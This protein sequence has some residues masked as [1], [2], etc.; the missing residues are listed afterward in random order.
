MPR[1]LLGKSYSKSQELL[2][3]IDHNC[4]CWSSEIL[5]VVFSLIDKMKEESPNLFRT[6]L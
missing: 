4:S 3:Q 5:Q 1:T 6:P 2:A